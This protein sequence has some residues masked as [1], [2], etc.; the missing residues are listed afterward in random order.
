M[1]KPND[2]NPTI[3]MRTQYFYALVMNRALLPSQTT[4][5]MSEALSTP[6]AVALMNG[7][8]TV[9]GNPKSFEYESKQI[10]QGLDVYSYMLVYEGDKR[11]RLKIGWVGTGPLSYYLLSIIKI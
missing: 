4:P 11:I 2:P 10:I 9:F 6:E 8:R 3:T 7:I 1:G 5:Q